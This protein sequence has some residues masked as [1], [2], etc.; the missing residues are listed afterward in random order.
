MEHELLP[1]ITKPTRITKTSATLIDNIIIGRNYQSTYT[2]MII[3][4][5]LSDHYPTLLEIPNLDIYKKQPMKISTRKLDY[6]SVAKIND[7][8][9]TIDW[10]SL[11][12]NLD[13]ESSF[14]T[15]QRTLSNTLDEITPVRVYHKSQ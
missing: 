15:Y 13:T 10:N 3:V 5:D 8:L 14:N 2:P 4:T 7:K 9:E 11:L 1:T 6:N 12:N